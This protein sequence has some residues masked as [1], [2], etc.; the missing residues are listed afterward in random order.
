MNDEPIRL[1][2]GPLAD[3]RTAELL[4]DAALVRH[5]AEYA[6]AWSLA[7]ADAGLIPQ[8]A[9]A[10]IARV[11]ETFAPDFARLAAGT[12]DTGTPVAPFIAQLGAAVAALEPAAAAYV[13]WGATSQDALDTAHVLQRRA[14]LARIDA[15]LASVLG[16][17]SAL[18]HTYRH[19]PMLARTLL[20][21]AEPTTFGLKVAR[22]HRGLADARRGLADARRDAE[23]LQFGGASGT[24]AAL[25]AQGIAVNEKVA[26]LLGLALPSSPWHSD[27]LRV[28]RLAAALG[29][30]LGVGGKIARDVALLAQREVGELDEPWHPGRGASSA[31]P[32]KRN[33]VGCAGL[34]AAALRAPGLVAT[35][36]GCLV[37]EHERALG[38]WHAEWAP[39]AE[40]L[41]LAAGASVGL[42][43]LAVGLVVHPERMRR[44]LETTGGDWAA[45]GLAAA[46]VVALGREEAHAHV[47]RLC[48][49]A[50]AQRGPLHALAR[51]D[52][53]VRRHLAPTDIDGLFDPTSR[54]AAVDALMARALAED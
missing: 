22:W 40:L 19:T 3:P 49:E 4:S 52:A 35:L 28:A 42:E 29:G 25:G 31:M 17:L 34:L 9:A 32:H 20:Q 44:N 15:I 45:S 13:H 43:A 12:R 36:Y 30:L 50:A 2:D 23:V 46:L 14:V 16:A 53:V 24:L 54:L 47:A 21:T 27:R 11:C 18:A 26:E 1:H 37:Q 41:S 5:L 38:A 8:G 33:P 10:Y 51:T 6:R 7:Q 39:L 48:A